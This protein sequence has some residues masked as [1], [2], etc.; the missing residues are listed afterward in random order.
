M[1]ISLS[2]MSLPCFYGLT[3]DSKGP[4]SSRRLGLLGGFELGLS[5]PE[6][7]LAGLR[8]SQFSTPVSYHGHS[9]AE[10]SEAV[11]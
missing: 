9:K 7:L 4:P 6:R 10:E 5:T 3:V 8:A 11:L 2:G 1:K